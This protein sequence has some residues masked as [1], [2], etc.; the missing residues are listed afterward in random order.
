MGGDEGNGGSAC[1]AGEGFSF[2]TPLKGPDSKRSVGLKGGEVDVGAV[3]LKSGVAAEMGSFA[4]EVDGLYVGDEEDGV[5]D[6]CV[7]EVDGFS[8]EEVVLDTVGFAEIDP[9][10]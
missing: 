4:G 1:A 2:K 3:G 5:G 6:A 8:C 9:D 7:E 10:I